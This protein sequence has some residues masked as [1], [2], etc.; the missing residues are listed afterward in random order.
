MNVRKTDEFIADV[1]RQFEWFVVNAGWEVADLYLDAV[2]ATCQ[3]LGQH[4]RLGPPGGF[5]HPCLSEWRFFL[6]FR[7][8]N[9]H[10]LFYE[11]LKDEVVLRRNA[12]APR[13]APPIA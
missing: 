9:K 13:L 4:P 1:E 7:P 5:S 8:F 2:K 11:L 6:V 12:R 3:L 10:I